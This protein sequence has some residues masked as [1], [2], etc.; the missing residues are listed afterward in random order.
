VE[1][2]QGSSAVTN[3]YTDERLTGISHTDDA[4]RSTGYGMEYDGKG[5]LT[6]VKVGG[7]TLTSNIYRLRNSNRW[8]Y[9]SEEN[10]EQQ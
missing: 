1:T 8:V 9:N 2:S 5:F 3:T 10:N 4:S 7:S 6:A